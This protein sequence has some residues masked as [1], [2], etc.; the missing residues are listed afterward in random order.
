M[1]KPSF[2]AEGIRYILGRNPEGAIEMRQSRDGKLTWLRQILE[3]Q[4]IDV[5]QGL[6]EL[7][8]LCTTEVLGIRS[9]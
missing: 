1:F 9:K 2:W 8:A 7:M 3:E 5:E 6:W 4:N